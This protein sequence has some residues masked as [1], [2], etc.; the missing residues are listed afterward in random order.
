MIKNVKCEI[1]IN[2]MSLKQI[3]VEKSIRS[4]GLHM[5]PS[6]SWKDHFTIIREKI[7]KGIIKL[8]R[9]AIKPYQIHVYFNMYI[10][11]SVFFRC[12]TVELM[13]KQ[14]SELKRICEASIIKKL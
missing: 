1:D 6:L 3:S 13:E 8:M 2:Q 4:L 11:T 12:T 7:I 10:L 14:I 9:M 5:L